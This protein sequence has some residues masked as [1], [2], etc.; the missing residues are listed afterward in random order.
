MNNLTDILWQP[1]RERQHLWDHSWSLGASSPTPFCD[2]R[3]QRFCVFSFSNS[4][5]RLGQ[6]NAEA[7]SNSKPPHSVT[8][9]TQSCASNREFKTLFSHFT[10]DQRKCGMLACALN[11]NRFNS[12]YMKSKSSSRTSERVT[13]C[14]ASPTLSWQ[15]WFLFRMFQVPVWSS[16]MGLKF[17]LGPRSVPHC[18]L[19]FHF[20]WKPGGRTNEDC[21]K[22]GLES[23]LR[24]KK[25]NLRTFAACL[26]SDS[27]GQS[28]YTLAEI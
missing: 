8:L 12:K 3:T 26:K 14:L 13:K 1:Q 17:W 19:T 2:P 24:W 11:F 16:S 18:A 10:S 21:G 23:C 25:P 6:L 28:I 20:T 22:R 9:Q 27:K 5:G 7:S 15:S 4:F